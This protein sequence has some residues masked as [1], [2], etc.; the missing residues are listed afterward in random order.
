MDQTKGMFTVDY[1]HPATKRQRRRHPEPFRVGD[2]PP[3][4]WPAPIPP[5][6]VSPENMLSITTHATRLHKKA[7]AL[8]TPVRLGES[9]CPALA[10]G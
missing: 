7:H 3:L 5:C 8:A 9:A 1:A 10:F 6:P 4:T 2:R